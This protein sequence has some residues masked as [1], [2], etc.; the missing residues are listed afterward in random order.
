MSQ[1]GPRQRRAEALV[2]GCRLVIRPHALGE[3]VSRI[4][5]GVTLSSGSGWLRPDCDGDGGEREC[6]RIV[7]SLYL[8]DGVGRLA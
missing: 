8:A 3:H 1:S 6:E 2:P 4:C 5:P 7:S